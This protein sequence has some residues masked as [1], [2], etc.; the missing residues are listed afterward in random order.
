[1]DTDELL[2]ALTVRAGPWWLAVP[3]RCIHVLHGYLRHPPPTPLPDSPPW[4]TG[5]VEGPA[6]L[7][8]VIHLARLGGAAEERP[9]RRH[10]LLVCITRP[11]L[12][13]RLEE[14]RSIVHLRRGPTDTAQPPSR[15][16]SYLEAG[17]HLDGRP[18]WVLAPER[19]A[20]LPGLSRQT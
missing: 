20:R 16:A 19:L 9:D 3:T 2:P 5:L 11:P 6:G 7:T 1:M 8:P 13:L 18:W 4:L 14:A 10:R 17:Y 12:A 15:L